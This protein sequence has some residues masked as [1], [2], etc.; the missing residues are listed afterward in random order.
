MQ[1][2]ES[3]RQQEQSGR[4]DPRGMALG[5]V[6][7]LAKEPVERAASLGLRGALGLLLALCLVCLGL[8]LWV[9][10]AHVHVR[11][12]QV[13]ALAVVVLA[14]NTKLSA[15]AKRRHRQLEATLGHIFVAQ[16]LHIPSS[17]APLELLELVK[18]A[19][20][21]LLLPGKFVNPGLS[22]R[23]PPLFHV[24]EVLPRGVRVLPAAKD[25]LLRLPLLF[26]GPLLRLAR[27]EDHL[28]L[29]RAASGA[30]GSSAR[31]KARHEGR[32]GQREEEVR[33]HDDLAQPG[34]MC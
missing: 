10:P 22:S 26:H 3:S 20:V 14:A 6:G 2:Q 19:S 25:F 31:H 8:V 16:L 23:L 33:A 1:S 7:S 29:R 11:Q 30:A 34:L 17:T 18:L 27:T 28:H 12:A 13:E 32:Q 5:V 24:L 21:L 15:H 9:H 4:R